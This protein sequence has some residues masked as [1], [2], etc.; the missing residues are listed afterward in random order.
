[1]ANSIATGTLYIVGTPIGNLEDITLRAIKTLN[2]VDL[3]AAEDTRQTGKLLQQFE[4]TT[5]QLSYHEHNRKQREPEIIE[6]LE[7]GNTIALVTD[8]GMPAVSDPGYDL[9]KTCLSRGIS[10]IPIPGVTAAITA[11]A[12]S[13]LPSNRF[14]FEGFLPV[15]GK[16]RDDRL[17][18]IAQ[19]KRTIILY[20][21]PHKL[22]KTLQDLASFCGE[23]RQLMLGRELTKIYETCHYLSLKQAIQ[24]YQ[25]KQ[26]KGEYTLVIAGAEQTHHLNLSSAE[27]RNELKQLLAQGMTR[28]QASKQLAKVT[29]L[30]RQQIYQ[31]S[32]ELEGS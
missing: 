21:S 3:I 32:I 6:K 4:I 15:K 20:E 25:D 7:Q 27:I 2:A 11:L 24:L 28:S 17:Y 12:V 26:P 9:V 14:V 1:M 31:L 18:A 30:S 23:T 22:K 10:V 13:G 19:E 8:A 16:A 29:S 5:P